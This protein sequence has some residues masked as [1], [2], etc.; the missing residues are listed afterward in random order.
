MHTDTTEQYEK[1]RT[2]ISY[3]IMHF[4]TNNQLMCNQRQ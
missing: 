2:R 4:N 3:E 1:K